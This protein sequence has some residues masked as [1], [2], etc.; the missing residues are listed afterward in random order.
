[1]PLNDPSQRAL[2]IE[3]SSDPQHCQ[4]FS[5]QCAFPTLH[6]A[7]NNGL[8]SSIGMLNIALCVVWHHSFTP[9]RRA[10]LWIRRDPLLSALLLRGRRVDTHLVASGRGRTGLPWIRDRHRCDPYAIY[11]HSSVI[12]RSSSY[13]VC[14]CT[15]CAN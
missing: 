9:K 14:L 8:S 3:Y 2:S 4:A 10:G 1:M 15:Y 12:G 11:L 5:I 7:L 13:Y 6:S